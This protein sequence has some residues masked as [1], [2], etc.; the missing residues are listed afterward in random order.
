MIDS[1][2]TIVNGNGQIKSNRVNNFQKQWKLIKKFKL[3]FLVCCLLCL[4]SAFLITRY[5]KPVY[6]VS[7]TISLSEKDK[8]N[9]PG[10][11]LVQSLDQ[12]SPGSS[13]TMDITQEIATLMAVPFITKTIEALDFKISYFRKDKIGNSEVYNL[14]PFNVIFPDTSLASKIR[15]KKIGIRFKSNQTFVV[16]DI[17]GTN[18]NTLYNTGK[19]INLNG[20]PIIVNT[21]SYFNIDRDIEKEYFFRNNYPSVLAFEFKD[22]LE[23]IP[24]DDES[25]ILEIVL[26]THSPEKGVKFLNELT[27]QYLIN[28]YEEKSRSASQALAFINEQINTVK[29]ALGGTE[30]SL[31]SFKAANTFSDPNAMTNRNLD[32]L[33]DVQN[34]TFNLKQQ[35]NYYSSLINDLNSNTSVDQLVSHSSVGIKDAATSSLMKEL[36]DLQTQ[37]NSYAA[38]GDSKNPYLQDID[39]KINAGKRTLRESISKLRNTNRSRLGQLNARAGQFQSNVYRI[40]LAEK[41]F[42]DINRTRDFND[43]LYQFLM[44]KRVEAGIMKAS[45]TVEDKII[46]PAYYST[47]PLEPKPVRN[48]IFG[49]VI[50]LL[51]PYGYVKLRS[52]LNKQVGGK[53]EIQDNTS[54]P[55]IGSIYHN[56]NTSALVI[57]QDSR[58][59]V[60]ESFR[61]LRYNL[62]QF[63]KDPSKKVILF[64]STKSGEGKSFSSINL[65]LSFAIAKKKTILMNL[66]LRLPSKSYEELSDSNHIGISSYLNGS[67]SLKEIIQ[68]TDNIYLDYIPTGELP[69]NPAELLMEGNK[70][71]N[72]LQHLRAIYDY[73]IIDTPPLGIVADPLIISSYSDLNVLIVREKY[74]LKES[75]FELEDM[76]KEGKIKNV[77]MVV[78]DVRLDKKGYKNAYYYKK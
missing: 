15:G 32:A 77:V 38:S 33:A 55:I 5:T 34:E 7:S 29:T 9:S 43:N 78:N 21:T 11:M 14:S 59:A 52:A 69:T 73:I 58:T 46:E 72:L 35:E 8:N 71:Q 41:Q 24:V 39:M 56:L 26:K 51:L 63:A 6:V 31:A 27:K 12:T 75:L 50:G 30:S 65:A 16:D 67:A 53:D 36:S 54:I 76:Y 20:C 45:A 68:P 74:T 2:R 57:K 37:K 60:S 48:Y 64:T 70:L 13:S 17:F 4:A 22:N 19:P 28:K 40:P 47:V 49:F 66:D 18:N 44:Q 61:I 25:G 42:T 3:L 23:V 1:F 10:K 62:A